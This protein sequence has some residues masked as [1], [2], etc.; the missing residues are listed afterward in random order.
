MFN[1][2]MHFIDLIALDPNSY[3]YQPLILVASAM[4][5]MLGGKDVMGTFNFDYKM[6]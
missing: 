5:L 2:L 6:F 1:T 4:Y 3:D